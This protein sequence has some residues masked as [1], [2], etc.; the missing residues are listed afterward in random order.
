[1]VE[2]DKYRT[3]Q[4]LLKRSPRRLADMLCHDVDTSK[5]N[6]TKQ[7]PEVFQTYSN[8][9]NQ[10]GE[11]TDH[12]KIGAE[13]K[14]T[15]ECLPPFT[16][17]EIQKRINRIKYSTSPG[18]DGICKRHLKLH[19]ICPVL[20]ELFNYLT[21]SGGYPIVWKKNKSLFLRSAKTCLERLDEGL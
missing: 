11:T 4:E 5:I 10:G 7:P 8:L 19:G 20:A 6:I 14:K 18:P 9:W 16:P 3:H 2:R 13:R 12:S 15:E 17:D 21:V 1:M